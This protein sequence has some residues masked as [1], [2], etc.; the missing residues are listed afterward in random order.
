MAFFLFFAGIAA[1]GE[2]MGLLGI[3][4]IL[5]AFSGD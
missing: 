2:G 4:L 3:M 5:A 1:L